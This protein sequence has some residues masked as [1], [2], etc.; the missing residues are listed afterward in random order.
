LNKGGAFVVDNFLEEKWNKVGKCGKD[1]FN[2]ACGYKKP[3]KHWI[4]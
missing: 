2:F 1:L 3:G 4:W